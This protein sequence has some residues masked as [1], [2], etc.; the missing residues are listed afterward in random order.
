M[1]RPASAMGMNLVQI[2]FRWLT[3]S[4][5]KAS[6]G[7]RTAWNLEG[8]PPSLFSHD[9]ISAKT[10]NPGD[11]LVLTIDPLRTDARADRGL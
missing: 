9:G 1:S 2:R 10:I 7:D 3:S 11:E 5:W 6:N 4:F 8:A